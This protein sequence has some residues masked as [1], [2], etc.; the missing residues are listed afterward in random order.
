MKKSSKTIAAGIG[1]LLCLPLFVIAA[2][3]WSYTMPKFYFSDAFVEVDDTPI[4]DLN[5]AFHQ[6]A[7][8][9][10]DVRLEKVQNTDLVVVHVRDS[11]AQKAADR[12]N[13]IASGLQERL[14]K[15]VAQMPQIAMRA[16]PGTIAMRPRVLLNMLVGGVLG[17]FAALAGIIVIILGS[18]GRTAKQSA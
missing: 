4:Q 13:A 1:L 5:T 15:Q 8:E 3:V 17:L 10:S 14:Q 11:D 6:V 9:S 7:P 12:A 18:G 16:E 2:G